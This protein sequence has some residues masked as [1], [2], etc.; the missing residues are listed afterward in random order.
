MGESEALRALPRGRHRLSRETVRA[1]QRERLLESV[2]RATAEKG[3]AAVT[4]GDIVARAATARRT[5]Y[6]HFQDKEEC[7]L[8]AF[9]QHADRLMATVKDAFGPAADLPAGVAAALDGFLGYLAADPVVARTYL[10][11]VGAAGPAAVACRLDIHRRFARTLVALGRASAHRRR[12]DVRPL[13][14][15]HALGVVGAV[16]ELLEQA[17]H[18]RGAERLPELSDDLTA[19]TVAFLRAD[20]RPPRKRMR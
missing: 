8:A 15:Q 2:T 5:F 20:V 9:N 10:I 17:L 18:E 13:T 4:I 3:F 1:S 11:E 7:F 12:A 14:Y 19:L 6:E 16:H